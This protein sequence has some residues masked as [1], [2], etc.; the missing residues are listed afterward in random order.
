[1]TEQKSRLVIEIDSRN[2]E[3][4]ARAI[5]NELQ[6]IEQNGNY[7]TRSMDSMS[8]ATRN[9]AGYMMGLVTVGTAISKMDTY[10]GLNNKLKLVTNS[11]TELN[12]ALSD[13]FRIAQNTAQAWDSISQIYQRFSDNAKR[14]NITQAQTAT[15]T[16]T[17]AK[18]ISISGGSAASAEAALIQFSQALASN[19]LRG[20]EL[21]SVMEQAPGLAKAIAQGMGITVGQLRSVAAE[22]KITGD[23]LV[24]ALTKAKGS[25][26]D[27]FSKTDFTISQSFTQLS[28]EVTKFVGEAGKGSGAATALSN[29]IRGLSENLEL[30]ANGALVIAVGFVTKA[31]T[32]KT[33]ATYNSIVA[34]TANIE[35]NKVAAAQSLRSALAEKIAAEAEI[36]RARDAVI[37]AEMQVQA[38]RKVIASEVQRIQASLARVE[39]E[40]SAEIQSMRSQYTD[41][42]RMKSS[43]RMAELQQIQ[44]T[45]TAELIA[46][47][48][49]LAATTVAS[50]VQC[51][52]AR[53]AQ[54]LA[55]GNLATATNIASVAQA[56]NNVVQ[57]AGL[58]TSSGL[59]GVLGGPVGLGVTVAALTATYFMFKDSSEDVNKSLSDQIETVSELAKHYRELTLAKLISE[60]DTLE[61]KLKNSEAQSN[62]AIASLMGVATATEHSTGKQ[63]KQS[64]VMNEIAI[65]L[66]DG[67]ISTGKALIQMRSS[68]FTED[69]IK[70]ASLFFEQFDVGKKGVNEAGHQLSFISQQ[71]GIYGNQLDG[72]TKKIAEQKAI[73]NALSGDYKNLSSQMDNQIQWL[74]QQD[75]ALNM[76]AEQ[77]KKVTSAV[78]AWNKK[79]IDATE[80]AKIFKANLPIDSNLL[81]GL[82][83]LAIKT[84]TAKKELGLANN[85]LKQVQVNGPKA[86]QGFIDTAQGAL[87]ADAKVAALNEKIKAFNKTLTDRKFEAEFKLFAVN[88]GLTDTQAEDL[89]KTYKEARAKDLKNIPKETGAALREAWNAD[90]QLKK[91]VDARSDAEKKVTDQKEK[92]AKLAERQ[93]VL[94]AGNNEQT[95]NMLRVYQSFRNAGL[96]DKAARVMT[97]QVGRENDYRNSDMF[98]SHKDANNGYTN[99]GFISWQK[100]RSTQL[101]QFLQGQGVLDTKWQDSTISR[102]FRC[103]G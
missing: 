4:N 42:G 57:R 51:V 86:K 1:M 45:M 47:E 98:G 70:K 77:Q 31:V 33:I 18:A 81:T 13:T 63:K 9:L 34:I 78:D 85:E 91:A 23:V 27:L 72:S 58:L 56:E 29:S 103:N 3:R 61:K 48:R 30:I 39:A 94:L 52:T 95:R 49:Q 7:A 79:T 90:D 88:K 62:K 101:M 40:K 6:S 80:L 89:F 87:D 76:S 65:N 69:Q 82:G 10:T 73:V 17:V 36:T 5:S 38:D 74:L 84:D 46:L 68:G 71:T 14:L 24:T 66:R 28:N 2:A 102:C 25:V 37:S 67:A 54:T 20:E 60:Q 26:D 96:E 19:V 41:T 55:T 15:L 93:A 12:K 97:A 99:T 50:S 64:D 44:A 35:A 59:L 21:N 53:E 32:A 75:S 83:D 11:Q 8:V 43:T 16:D 100:G 22:G 92:Q